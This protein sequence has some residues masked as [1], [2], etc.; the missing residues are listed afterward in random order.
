MSKSLES[1][2]SFA[3]A[4]IVVTWLTRVSTSSMVCFT[5]YRRACR[6]TFSKYLIETG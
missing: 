4:D 2:L 1:P 6:S 5:L 3:L